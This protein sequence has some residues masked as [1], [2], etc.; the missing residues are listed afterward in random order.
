VLWVVGLCSPAAGANRASAETTLVAVSGLAGGG[1]SAYALGRQGWVW[2]WGDNLEGQL[3]NGTDNNVSNSPVVVHGL[4]GARELA[5]SANSAFALRRDGTVW[6]WGDD[7]QGELGD[8]K[9][10][11]TSERPVRVGDLRGIAEIGAGEFSAYALTADGKVW[12]WG[13]NSL[14]QVGQS[15]SVPG[16]DVPVRVNGLSG[17]VQLAAGAST[18]YVLTTDGKVWAWG[19]NSFGELARPEPFAGSEFPVEVNGL[20]GGAVA[21]AAGADAGFALLRDGTVRSWGDGSFGELGTGSCPS[22]HPTN[23]PGSYRP[24]T[25]RHLN[26]VKAL[27]A[28]TYAGYALETNGTVWAWGY[29]GYGQ[30]GDGSR[31]SSDVPMRVSGL[32]HVVMIAA[33]SNAAYA[34][35]TNGTVWA[36]G[37]GGYGQLGNGSGASSEVPVRVSLP[38]DTR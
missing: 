32:A 18:A 11:Y 25:V 8:G 36:W 9:E 15:L 30:L 2:A 6:A 28:G 22:A 33:G 38:R 4:S 27:A 19:D 21:V 7:G 35:E 17:A 1:Y 23:C 10:E 31:A 20:G 37:Y 16:T 34:L 12:A 29:G 13:D 14:G 24:T 26:H 3:G 5:A